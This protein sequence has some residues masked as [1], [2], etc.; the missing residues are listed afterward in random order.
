MD[1]IDSFNPDDTVVSQLPILQNNSGSI[2]KLLESVYFA[3]DKLLINNVIN[4]S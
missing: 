4:A 1:G 3:A 2:L